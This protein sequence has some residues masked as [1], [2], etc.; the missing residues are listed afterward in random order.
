MARV[1]A[2]APDRRHPRPGHRRTR[3]RRARER[4][5]T[6]RAAQRRRRHRRPARKQRPGAGH[7]RR[8]GRSPRPRRGGLRQLH[9]HAVPAPRLRPPGAARGPRGRRRGAAGGARVPAAPGRRV[10][11]Q[12]R[13]HRGTSRPSRP[14]PA[15][16]PV[17]AVR[18]VPAGRGRPQGRPVLAALDPA[19]E[20]VVNVNEPDDYRTAR[21][22]PA[23]PIT[24]QRFGVLASGPD[25][26]T[27]AGD[28]A[29]GHRGRS[30]RWRPA[31]TSAAGTSR[32]R[33]T[34][35]RSPGTARRRWPRATPSSSCRPTR[36]AER[37]CRLAATSAGPS[38]STPAPGPRRS[39]SF[40]TTC[41][42]RTSAAPGSV[43]G[44]CT[45]WARRG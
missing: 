12:A 5:G 30:R 20:S 44:S 8:A 34:G 42:A 39:S 43:P 18:G 35:T 21:Q 10:P 1:D 2:V 32:R 24:V 26:H 36:G 4:P 3:G 27:Q 33:S 6:A 22:K 25:G 31:S 45:A 7:S 28:G 40:P 15:G 19:L 13:R 38:S 14:P 16:L 9:R 29:R 23:P 37:R 11:H 17:R 41:C